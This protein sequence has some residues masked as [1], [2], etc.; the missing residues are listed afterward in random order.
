LKSPLLAAV[1]CLLCGS[2]AL[3]LAACGPK[4]PST[5]EDLAEAFARAHGAQDIEA[6][7]DLIHWGSMPAS[8]RER[9]LDGIETSFEKTVASTEVKELPDDFT[10]VSGP[11]AFPLTP[12]KE[13]MVNYANPAQEGGVL[14][15]MGFNLAR[16]DGRPW[17][18]YRSEDAEGPVDQD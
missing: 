12:E 2:L 13:L 10:L 7:N 14:V 5:Y 6:V 8:E 16:Q 4:T 3:A 15:G 18:V 11:Y 1:H 9:I 17:I